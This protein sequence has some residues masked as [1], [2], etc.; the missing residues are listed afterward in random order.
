MRPVLLLALLGL[1]ACALTPATD[2]D[3]GESED[4]VAT[5]YVDILDFWQTDV[6]QGQ[7]LDA[8][9]KL[10]AEFNDVCGDT[11]CGGDYSNLT[12]LGLTCGV[13]SKAG[14]IRDCVWTFTGSLELVNPT[15]AALDTSVPSW[16]CHVKP[17]TTAAKLSAL[18]LANGSEPAIRR[19]LPGTTTSLYDV[20]G[21]C[22][23]HPI[24]ATAVFPQYPPKVTYMEALDYASETGGQG[25]WI[26]AREGLRNDFDQVCGDTFCGGDYTNLQALRFACS[27]TR[28]T[29]NVK[30]CQWLF[31]GSYTEVSPK[32]GAVTVNAKSFRCDVPVH[33]TEKQLAAVLT[34]T[35]STPAIRRPLPGGSAS[36][37]DA[38]GQCL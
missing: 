12:S 20:L 33:G 4:G 19:V 18:I 21:E 35:S 24:G 15:T 25:T 37:Y 1:G 10:D 31:G 38:L 6:S 32:T 30:R 14:S 28:S 5:S 9:R 26:D 13:S 34:Q 23:Q 16:Q 29:G 27:I 36:A 7:W 11:F 3:V 17:K 8:R 22:F 2:A